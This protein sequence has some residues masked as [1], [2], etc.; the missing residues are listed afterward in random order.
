MTAQEL[1][2]L[3]AALAPLNES[4]REEEDGSFTLC[5]LTPVRKIAADEI[6]DFALIY[7]VVVA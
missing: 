7:G 3:N 1:S 6:A 2:D 4:I 5:S